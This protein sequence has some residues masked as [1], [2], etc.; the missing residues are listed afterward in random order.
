MSTAAHPTR[1]GVFGGAFDP[2][3]IAHV[4]LVK[5]A[6]AQFTLD[7]VHVLPTGAAWHKPRE[8]SAAE[9]RL[10]MT[11]LAFDSQDTVVVDDRE[12]RRPG[13]TYT[14]DTL[15][16]L[17]REGT[18]QGPGAALYL[19]IGA[20]QAAALTTWHDWRSILSLATICVAVRDQ[21]TRASGAF[22][23]DNPPPELAGGRFESLN[24]ES[25]PVSATDIRA[26]VARG[27]DISAL[28]APAVA[29]YIAQHHLYQ[30]T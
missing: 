6:I 28:V 30:T 19:I 26:R 20:D 18:S 3:H 29:R 5:A 25:T 16:E 24:F 12:I 1:I 17:A 2:P 9:H 14:A 21:C 23:A 8:L 10:A 27:Q 7:A 22:D 11:R 15:R 13:P 4:A